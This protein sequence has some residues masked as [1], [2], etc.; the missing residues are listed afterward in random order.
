MNFTVKQGNF[1]GIIIIIKMS[2]VNVYVISVNMHCKTA[3]VTFSK[4]R[5]AQRTVT[6]EFI[7][8]VKY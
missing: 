4:W 6:E 5:L 7:P 8:Y 3:K 2:A 1:H